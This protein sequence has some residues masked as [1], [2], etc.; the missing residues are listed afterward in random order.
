M[1]KPTLGCLPQLPRRRRPSSPARRRRRPPPRAP[2]LPRL[3]VRVGHVCGLLA[4]SPGCLAMKP[5]GGNRSRA[6]PACHQIN[7]STGAR[8]SSPL[9][10]NQRQAA[11]PPREANARVASCV[12]VHVYL[13]LRTQTCPGP[14]QIGD[15][16][17]GPGLISSLPRSTLPPVQAPLATRLIISRRAI[18][19]SRQP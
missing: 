8:V 11:T 6:C 3:H 19:W 16:E 2:P 12:L 9:C 1:G 7:K 4:C 17:R 5:G 18:L 15:H 13:R 10:I 14:L